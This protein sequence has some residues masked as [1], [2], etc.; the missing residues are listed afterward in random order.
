MGMIIFSA[1]PL[2]PRQPDPHFADEVAAAEACGLAI[3][4]IDLDLLLREQDAAGAIRHI[5]VERET[6]ALLRSWMIPVAAYTHL[7]QA[8]QSRGVR[9][10]TNP[11]SYQICHELP[12]A[13]PL[14]TD[15][16]SAT[17]WLPEAQAADLDAL[18]SAIAPLGGGPAIVKD[19]V[20][21]LADHW[22]AACFIPDT[23]D[24]AQVARVVD[25]FRTLRGAELQGGL[26]FRAYEPFVRAGASTGRPIV[27]EY[28]RYVIDGQVVASVPYW[29]G[30]ESGEMPPTAELFCDVI[31][32]VP[33]RF[34]TIDIALRTD[35][36]WRIVELGDGQ[37][38]GLV[39]VVDRRTLYA[40]LARMLESID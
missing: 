34:F 18:M 37:V 24:R 27:R 40:R 38:A 26:M 9:L 11:M 16:T 33:S 28:R 31:A 17:I 32:Q 15:H 20:K 22:H 4:V 23:S 29:S 5:S 1:D 35:G 25:R 6:P 14:I 3:G 10:I 13:Y 21:S 7:C 39:A 30:A 8:L 36:V 12:A 19:F 2:N